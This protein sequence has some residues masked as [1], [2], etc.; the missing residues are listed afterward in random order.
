MCFV[1]V[2]GVALGRAICR[3]ETPLTLFHVRD[4]RYVDLLGVARRDVASVAQTTMLNGRPNVMGAALV[5]V[6]GASVFAD[7]SLGRSTSVVARDLH[8]R[9][10]ARVALR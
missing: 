10:L 1:P 8:G 2:D 3:L 9:T 7:G 4:G 5:P 6:A